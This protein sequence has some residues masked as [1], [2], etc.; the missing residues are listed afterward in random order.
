M[1]YLIDE[2]KKFTVSDSVLEL[3]KLTMEL[4]N[5]NDASLVDEAL[6]IQSMKGS[7]EDEI[8]PIIESYVDFSG[9]LK[10]EDRKTLENTYLLTYSELVLIE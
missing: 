8:D 7:F 10:D 4:R 3:Y 6:F 9:D 1:K 2:T 5:L